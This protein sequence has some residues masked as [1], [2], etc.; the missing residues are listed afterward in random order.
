MSSGPNT[1]DTPEQLMDAFKTA[2]LSVT[3]LYKTSAAAQ[4]KARSDGYQDCLEDLIAFLDRQNI[5]LGD[6]D[7]RQIRRWAIERLEGRDSALSPLDSEDEAEKT[8]MA[9]S[10]PDMH[11]PTT[12]ANVTVPQQPHQQP[13]QSQPTRPDAAPNATTLN[14]STSAT[15]V[16]AQSSPF[17]VPTLDTFSFQSPTAYPPDSELSIANLDL[18][19]SRPSDASLHSGTQAFR[20]RTTR[21]GARP[22]GGHVGRVAGQKRR[23]NLA[24]IFDVGGLG[25]KDVFGGGGGGK[26]TK[27]T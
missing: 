3:K 24:E 1:L 25:G 15:T 16:A 9:S 8:E 23:I 6:G 17:V 26:R 7:S 11:P 14:N 21:P 20:P 5:G 4:A 27:H 22:R 13:Q 18:S 10:S 19:D 2:A 12:D